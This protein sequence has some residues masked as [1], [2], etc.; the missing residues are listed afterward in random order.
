MPVYPLNYAY[1]DGYVDNIQIEHS[2]IIKVDGWHHSD[3]IAAVPFPSCYVDGQEIARFQIFR[4]YRPDVAAAL[5]VAN[6]FLGTGCFYRMPGFVGDQQVKLALTF[7]QQIIF[8]VEAVFNVHEPHYAP[9]LDTPQVLHRQH[10]YD[11][12]PPADTVIEETVTLAKAL[13]DP[14]LDFGC[15]SGVLIKLLREH[16]VEAYG[17]EL[18]RQ[19]IHQHLIPAMQPFITLYDG[20]FPLP[21]RDGQFR[22]VVATEVIEHVPNYE[23][24]LGEIARVASERFVI[25]VPDMSAI[26]ISHHNNVVPWH[27]LEATHVNFFTQTS[28]ERV[29]RQFFARV[30]MARVAPNVTNDSTWFGHLV[31]LCWK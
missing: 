22:S 14:V 10:I 23:E 20:A 31:G 11:S 28:L 9:L 5:N 12:G 21:Y 7:N 8:E 3:T 6:A 16:D 4:T 25:T 2:G 24:A 19:L 27:L 15:G 1:G 17:I 13:P 29:L 30:E 26:P 18:D